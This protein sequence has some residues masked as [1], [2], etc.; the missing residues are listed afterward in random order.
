[1]TAAESAPRAG[2]TEAPAPTFTTFDAWF[3][4]WLS[5]IIARKLTSTAGKNRVFCPRWWCD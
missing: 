5:G 3:E 4:A 2:A 1:V